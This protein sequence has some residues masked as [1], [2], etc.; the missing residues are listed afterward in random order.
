MRVCCVVEGAANLEVHLAI[1]RRFG[2]PA[3]P[4]INRFPED[5]ADWSKKSHVSD[6]SFLA[7]RGDPG[8]FS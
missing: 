6:N 5:T 7:L 2:V 3:V 4:A 1:I 8:R